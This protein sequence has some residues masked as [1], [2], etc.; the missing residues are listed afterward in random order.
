MVVR[1][2]RDEQMPPELLLDAAH[3]AVYFSRSREEN[4]V[5][6]QY[7]PV[8]QLKKLPTPGAVI[9]TREKVIAVR[10][11]HAHTQELLATER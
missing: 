4:L 2:R 5:D 3:L 1:L 6:V 8:G 7:T 11:D 9:L 10:V